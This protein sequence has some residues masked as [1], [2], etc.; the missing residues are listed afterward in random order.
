MTLSVEKTSPRLGVRALELF[1]IFQETKKRQIQTKGYY[2]AWQCFLKQCSRE[3]KVSRLFE[4][5]GY[6][7]IIILLL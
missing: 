3:R 4:G 5:L 2:S 6:Y 1:R 7:I